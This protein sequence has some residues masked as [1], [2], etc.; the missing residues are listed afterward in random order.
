MGS[1][2][3]KLSRTAFNADGILGT[4]YDDEGCQVAVTLEHSFNGLPKLPAGTYRCQ[5][6]THRLHS[7]PTPFDTFEVM[8]VPHH[9]GI[10]FHPGNYHDDSNGC[11]LVGRVCHDSEKG[12]MVTDSRNTFARFML[13]LDEVATFTLIVEDGRTDSP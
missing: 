3:V 8:D 6:G 7:I 10:L 9:T 13:D 2:A 4:L 5:R 1:V 12:C 11:I